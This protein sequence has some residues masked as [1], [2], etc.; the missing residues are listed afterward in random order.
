[1][2]TFGERKTRSGE[3]KSD[4]VSLTDQFNFFILVRKIQVFH[5]GKCWGEVKTLP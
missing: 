3:N 2:K 1:M 4:G 5:I